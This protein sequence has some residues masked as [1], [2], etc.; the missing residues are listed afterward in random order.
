MINK[1]TTIYPGHIDFPDHNE[2]T[3]HRRK[4]MRHDQ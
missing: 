3:E 4:G 1:F 2:P